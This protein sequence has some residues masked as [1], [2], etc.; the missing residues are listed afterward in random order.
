MRPCR[1]VC[2]YNALP[3]HTYE[4]CQMYDVCLTYEGCYAN[5]LCASY[6]GVQTRVQVWGGYD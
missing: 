2:R 4:A 6:E 3:C 5:E 1:P